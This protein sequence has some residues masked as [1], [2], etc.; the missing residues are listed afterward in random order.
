MYNE[1]ENTP[2]EDKFVN[3]FVVIF[4]EEYQKQK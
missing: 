4:D 2:S 1:N 3:T